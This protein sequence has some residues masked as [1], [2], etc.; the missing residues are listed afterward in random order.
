MNFLSTCSFA[1]VVAIVYK[2]NHTQRGALLGLLSGS[3]TMI[4][5]MLLWNWLITPLYMGVPRQ[6][7]EEMLL[8][9]FLPFNILK[10]GLNT[11]ITLFIYKPLVTALRKARLI[12]TASPKTASAKKGIY[13]IG[14]FL[15]ATCL[16]L[17]LVLKGIL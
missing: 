2:K 3:V 4:V 1:C 9:Y 7:V 15:L 13:L 11:A 8:P 10:A 16:L 5:V 14:L 6:A 17:F 12:E